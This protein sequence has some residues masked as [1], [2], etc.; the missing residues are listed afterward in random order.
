MVRLKIISLSKSFK[1]GEHVVNACLAWDT[2]VPRTI[3][4]LTNVSHLMLKITLNHHKYPQ[5][6]K[7]T[8][9]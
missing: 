4:I 1:G 7:N 2:F 9:T 3:G 8:F 6:T 5:N